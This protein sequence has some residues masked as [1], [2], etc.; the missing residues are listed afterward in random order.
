MALDLQL[1]RHDED[2]ETYYLNMGPQHPAMHGV[3]RLVL[4]LRGEEILVCEP[5]IGYAHRAHEKMAENRTVTQFLPNTSRVDYLSGL[6]YNVAFCQTVER[7]LGVAVP[8]RA[9][10]V[11]V[12]TCELNRIASHLLF[13]GS[14]A[15]DLGAWTPFLYG[16]DDREQ[17]VAILE[18]LTGSRLTYCYARFGGVARDVDETFLDQATGFVAHM[19]QRLPDYWRLLVD[20]VIFRKRTAGVGR[21]DAALCRRF[22]ITGPALRA[23]G[24]AYDV[25][26]AE[27]YGI[28]ERFDFD[29]PTLTAADC[30]DRFRVRLLEIE[31]SLRIVEQAVAAIPEGPVMPAKKLRK[32][33]IPVGETYF[34]AESPRGQLGIYLVGDGT[35]RPARLKLRTPSLS[36]LSSMADALRGTL[37]ADTIA[38]LGSIDPILPEVDR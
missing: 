34:A 6:I 9:E 24:V 17:I 29:V 16:F 26:R 32:T 15:L 5:V 3:L 28:Y 2:R 7:A 11:R 25:R 1:V 19:R 36:N 13:V 23:A 35:E 30:L 37:I 27:P 18:R 4:E 8:E 14:F 10:F 21:M 22:G 33:K 38:I 20:N 31:Q 12:I